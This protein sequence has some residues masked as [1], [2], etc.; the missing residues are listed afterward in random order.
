MSRPGAWSGPRAPSGGSRQRG[1]EVC[2]AAGTG[3][4]GREVV[5]S[6]EGPAALGGDLREGLAFPLA[7]P[8]CLPKCRGAAMAHARRLRAGA[9]AVILRT[10]FCR[11]SFG[12]RNESELMAADGCRDW[13]LLG[14]R[15]APVPVPWLGH[16]LSTACCV[17]AL[18]AKAFPRKRTCHPIKVEVANTTILCARGLSGPVAGSWERGR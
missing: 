11:T 5:P 18:L 7:S 13:M 2:G 12:L 17:A 10:A 3:C 15:K 4:Q 9:V 1:R 8:A 16:R 6:W 14:H